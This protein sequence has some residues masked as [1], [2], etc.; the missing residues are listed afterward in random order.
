MIHYHGTPITPNKTL[1][2]LRN[3][4]F[5][6]SFWR[7]DN[8]CLVSEIASTYAIDN[9]AFSAWTKGVQPD[10]EMYR[11][12]IHTWGKHHACD[13][14]VIPDK[15]DGTEKEND[16]MIESWDESNGVPV[17]HMHESLDR[18]EYLCKSFTKVALGSSGQYATI[19]DQKW[20]DRMNEVMNTIVID[21]SPLCKIHG[22]R[23][24]DNKLR[25]YPFHSADSTNIAQNLTDKNLS[26]TVKAMIIRER[27]ESQQSD[28]WE[29]KSIEWWNNKLEEKHS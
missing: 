10:W 6:V 11:D 26:R 7:P 3:A 14:H 23:M 4:H 1:L 20:Y 25:I 19:G 22:L 17:W 24:L 2:A 27:I 15:I 18:L 9:G 28:K 16:Q 5:F 12:F 21:G 13:F 29:D 8:I